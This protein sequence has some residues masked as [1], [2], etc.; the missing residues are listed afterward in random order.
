MVSTTEG[1]VRP[2]EGVPDRLHAW[3]LTA[4]HLSFM[5][6][7]SGSVHT[8]LVLSS[9]VKRSTRRTSTWPSH[10]V[11]SH[12]TVEHVLFVPVTLIST[13]PKMLLEPFGDHVFKCRL[14]AVSCKAKDPH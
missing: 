10:Q 5:E 13:L 3:H 11:Y 4:P 6:D 7:P 8:S 9:V 1:M 14:G 12:N 2:T